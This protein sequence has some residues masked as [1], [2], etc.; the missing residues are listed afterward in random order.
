V[1][2]SATTKSTMEI[3][4]WEDMDDNFKMKKFVGPSN[5][6]WIVSVVD[7]ALSGRGKLA[8]SMTVLN[9][10][11]VKRRHSFQPVVV[12][13]HPPVLVPIVVHLELSQW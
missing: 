2:T 13:W 12:L 4:S 8:W 9:L 11:L 7:L 3:S 10:C 6:V 5:V 1:T